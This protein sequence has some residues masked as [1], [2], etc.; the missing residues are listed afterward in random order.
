M[1]ALKIISLSIYCLLMLIVRPC[2]ANEIVL[3]EVNGDGCVPG[4]I[5]NKVLTKEQVLSKNQSVKHFAFIHDNCSAGDEI[6]VGINGVSHHLRRKVDEESRN[7][8]TDGRPFEGDNIVA[9]IKKQLL[10]AKFKDSDDR[11]GG[12]LWRVQVIL[13]VGRQRKIIDGTLDYSC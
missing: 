11:C 4:F 12:A 13:N 1:R 6:V 2:V 7:E 9:S 10:I 3:T 8:I 5:Y